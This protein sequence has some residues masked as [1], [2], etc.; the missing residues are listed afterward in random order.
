VQLCTWITIIGGSMGLF[1]KLPWPVW[2]GLSPQLL[3]PLGKL[4]PD[5]HSLTKAGER[6]LTHVSSL[7]SGVLVI[8][9]GSCVKIVLL[10]QLTKPLPGAFDLRPQCWDAD[11]LR[12]A[13]V[14]SLLS[15]ARHTSHICAAVPLHACRQP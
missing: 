10:R 15:S 4:L 2:L 7:C 5:I 1:A 9:S 6:G 13:A 14:L 12:L 8:T 3:D 11:L